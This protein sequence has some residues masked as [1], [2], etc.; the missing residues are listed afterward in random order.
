MPVVFVFAA[1]L[2]W[3][4][5]AQPNPPHGNRYNEAL[6]VDCVY[7]H[8]PTDWR[9]ATKAAFEVSRKMSDMVRALNGAQLRDI[10]E[11]DCW[12]C[13][14]GDR[15]PARQPRA[16]L[17][18]ELAAWPEA[19]AGAAQSTK[20]AMAVYDVALG[21]TC[22]YCHATADWK[23]TTKKPMTRVP[24]MLEMFDEFPKYMPEKS[25]IQCYM[26]HKGAKKPRTSPRLP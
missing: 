21:V 13:H 14:A 6:G 23:A 26:C 17:D 19:L 10:G 9:A 15:K 16:A 20:I 8:E 11:V 5:Q 25:V 4:A 12:T 22:D 18:H 3:A 1:I 2:A 24:H 7:C